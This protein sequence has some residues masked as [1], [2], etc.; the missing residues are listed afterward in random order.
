MKNVALIFLFIFSSLVFLTSFEGRCQIITTVAGCGTACPLGDGGQATAA[1]IAVGGQ[2][3]CD[4]FGNFYLAC[5]GQNRIRKVNVSTGII[6]TVAGN[7]IFGFFGDGG[8]ATSA[9][10]GSAGSVAFDSYNNMYISDALN[11]RIRKVDASTGIIN[12]I[13]GT[14]GTTYSGDGGLATAASFHVMGGIAIDV[15]GNIFISDSNRIRKIDALTGVINLY[16]GTSGGFSGDGGAA[17]AA[18]LNGPRSICVDFYGNIYIEDASNYR[19]RKISTSGIITTVAGNGSPTYTGDGVPATATGISTFGV[20]VDPSGNVYTSDYANHRVRMVDGAGVIH[21]VAGT[22]IPGFSGDGTPATTAELS[23]PETVAIGR[24]DNNLYIQDFGN[25]RTRKVALTSLSPI[26]NCTPTVSISALP[27]DTVCSGASVTFYAIISSGGVTNTYQWYKNGVIVS[28]AGSTYTYA[29]ANGDSV[30]CIV[31]TSGGICGSPVTV[32]SNSIFMTTTTLSAISGLSTL[33]IGNTTT[34]SDAT[35]GGIWSSSNPAVAAVGSGSG[36]VFGISAGGATITYTNSGGC[37]TTK[38]VTVI[39]SPSA[40]TINGLSAV[41]AGATVTLSDTSGSGV[42]SVSNTHATVSASGVVT[43]VSAGTVVI[44]YMITFTCGSATATKTITV[45]VSPTAITGTSTICGIDTVTLSNTVAGGRWSSSDLSVARVDTSTGVVTSHGFGVAT[46]SYTIGNCFAAKTITVNPMPDA[47]V[48]TQDG[49]DAFCLGD[50]R[51][52]HDTV[53]GGI[54][55][56]ENGHIQLTGDTITAISPGW[57]SIYYTVTNSCGTAVAALAMQVA[58]PVPPISGRLN[59]CIGDTVYLTDSM[60]GGMWQPGSAI[61]FLGSTPGL[62]DTGILAGISAG[63]T[64]ITYQ[65]DMGCFTIATV[66]VNPLPNAGHIIGSDTVCI[67]AGIVLKDSVSGG[68]WRSYPPGLVNIDSLTGA[69]NTLTPGNVVITFN[70]PPDIHGCSNADTFKLT[71]LPGPNFSI[72]SNITPIKCFGATGSIAAIVTGGSGKYQYLWVSG[73]TVAVLQGVSAGNYMIKVKD[74]NTR[75]IDS[76]SFAIMQPD[77][78]SVALE[79]KKDECGTHT[80]FINAN[81]S[82][83]TSPYQY[84]WSNSAT[85]NDITGLLA[86]TYGLVLTDMNGCQKNMFVQVGDS[87]KDLVIHDAISPNGDGINDTWIID[88]LATYPKNTVQVFDKWGDLVFEK[89]D[90]SNNWDGIGMS[91]DLLPDGTYYY[92]VKLN[93]PNHTGGPNIFKG[94]LLIKR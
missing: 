77:S 21:T 88:G 29:P 86:G 87:C 37:Y 40:G 78:L 24:C 83:G 31:T 62:G 61:A 79:I 20:A 41:C 56:V 54:W 68:V 50:V 13:A 18:Q 89:T 90:Y 59:I 60:Y 36:I 49:G 33:C 85:G 46:I 25:H 69:V 27:S 28:T 35:P 55:S 4:I 91:G 44:S 32:S 84:Q 38:P 43:G 34:L 3:A 17:I 16:A 64:I 92:L 94:A 71:V 11:Y 22:G 70:V 65:M 39:L 72:G 82:G 63:T 47:G 48:I 30:R 19:I 8:P 75:C 74:V 1:N 5:S 6:T 7:G 23:S 93:E 66:T 15:F 76:N 81:V 57:D 45:N 42:W 53:P 67:N 9:K 73:D 80:G 52:V 10:L 26:C 51:H 2:V 14:G 58:V 12:T